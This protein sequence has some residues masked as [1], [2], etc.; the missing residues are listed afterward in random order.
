MKR[1]GIG[2]VQ[3]FEIRYDAPNE[4][5]SPLE[6]MTT[7]WKRAFRRAVLLSDR[8]NLDFSIASSAGWSE[9]GGPWVTPAHAMKKL[10]WSETRINGG[11]RITLRLP[12]PPDTVGPFQNANADW[13]VPFLGRP[14]SK[15]ITQF[16]RDVAVIAFRL[17]ERDLAMDELRPTVRTS[18]GEVDGSLLWDGDFSTG[19]RLPFRND[20]NPP[21]IDV[22]FSA[23][24]TIQSMTLALEMARASVDP[25]H[26]IAELQSRDENDKPHTIITAQNVADREQTFSFPPETA[27]R[28]RLILYDPAGPSIPPEFSVLFGPKQTEH[29]ILEFVLHTTPRTDHFER[30]AGFFVGNELTL[31]STHTYL[32]RDIVDRASVQNL[33]SYV[34]EDGTLDWTPPV[35]RWMVMRFGYSPIGTTNHPV[36]LDESGLEVDKLS[37][38]NVESYESAYLSRY[39]NSVGARLIGKRGI[40][41]LVNDSWEAGAQNWTDNLP[42]E[43]KRRRG[44]ELLPW[45]PSLA[46]WVQGNSEMTERFLWDFRRT[47]GELVVENYYRETSIAAH[48]R[49]MKHYGESHELGRQFIG[50]GM[51]AK[52]YDDV[53]MGAMWVDSEATPAAQFDA[54][55][56]ESASVAHIYGKK[57][58]AAESMTALGLPGTAYALSPEMIMPTINR[59]LSDGVNLL[60]IHSSV[61]Q[62]LTLIGPGNTLGPYGLWFTRNETWAEEALPWINYIARASYLLQQGSFVADVAYYYG[63]DSN[64]TAL[65][66]KALPALPT[67]YAF[68]FINDAALRALSVRDGYLVSKTNA[69]YKVL[70][71]DPRVTQMSIDV[72][73]ELMRLAGDGAV[74][75]ANKPLSTPSLADSEREFDELA[76]ALWGFSENG[77]HTYGKGKVI[78]DTSLGD[79]FRELGESPDFSYEGSEEGTSISFVHRQL[80]NGDIYFVS[81]RQG[82]RRR[83]DAKFRVSGRLPEIWNADTGKVERISYK[84]DARYTTVSLDLQP[85]ESKFV[86]FLKRAK[87]REK[88]IESPIRHVLK[89]ISGP[90]RVGFEVNRGAP[91]Q[92]QFAKLVPWNT[93]EVPGIKYFSGTAAYETTLFCPAGWHSAGAKL[94]LDLGE[95]KNLAEV[96]ING[97]SAGI[98]WKPPFRADITSLL[99]VGENKITI[100]VT[101]L[102]PNRLIG[103]RQPG[104]APVAFA[105]FNPYTVDSPLLDS[106]LL[107]P[108][109]VQSVVAERHATPPATN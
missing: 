67:G 34:S 10:V 6:F 48:A 77:V 53:P 24:Q 16:Y 91:E 38:L 85:Y 71:V 2:G 5:A 106:G 90:W 12:P 66:G 80:K 98:V 41:G 40:S 94:N 58:V 102:W 25:T 68:D 21:W 20:N 33:T 96:L 78:S 109:T 46:G 44:Y 14:P 39:R 103:D 17:P 92:S 23:P 9:A 1:V 31:S 42:S 30:K 75:C 89:A 7:P 18:T 69:K 74:I 73:H 11:R 57:V 81:N 45:L 29:R 8:L 87:Y 79:V 65:Y 27:K 63:Q 56:L 36:S 51:D 49:G 47:L 108:V 37:R 13:S 95:V 22:E 107:G 32:P 3:N 35:G 76:N 4:V 19:V 93:S 54:D 52:R 105:P 84:S 104:A 55:L 64:V 43:F 26:I 60:V 50:D 82:F 72:V 59:E 99:H 62:P 70:A 15:P 83:V 97:A 28:F 86:L 61:H 100:R 88:T 101:N